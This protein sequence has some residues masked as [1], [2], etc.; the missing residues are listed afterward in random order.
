M[1][2]L[3]YLVLL[4]VLR[5]VLR[6]HLT[7]VQVLCSRSL[8]IIRAWGVRLPTWVVVCRLRLP[9]PWA[10][11]ERRRVLFDRKP[12]QII[13]K[14]PQRRTISTTR[15][16]TGHNRLRRRR[17]QIQARHSQKTNSQVQTHTSRERS[18]RRR[19]RRRRRRRKWKQAPRRRRRHGC[20]RRRR[21]CTKLVR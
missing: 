21:R 1:L 18:Q 11:Q 17:R 6:L 16:Q 10:W 15:R 19:R 4:R 8:T 12:C 2:L 7:Q 3:V 9:P 20:R 14:R 5:V 13:A